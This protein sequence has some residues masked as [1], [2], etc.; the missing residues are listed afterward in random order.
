MNNVSVI[1]KFYIKLEYIKTYSL[2][3]WTLNPFPVPMLFRTQRPQ[4]KFQ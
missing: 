4:K 2:N 1:I 3:S